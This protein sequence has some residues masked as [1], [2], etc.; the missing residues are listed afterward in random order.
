M[1]NRSIHLSLHIHN[2]PEAMAERA[3]HIFADACEEAIAERGIFRVA[4]SGGKTP[5]P[6]F[7]LL[8]R[9]D[10]TQRLPWN[11]IALYWVD[12]RCVGPDDP[13]SNYGMARRELLTHVPAIQY[14]RMRG[15]EDPVKAAAKYE[16]Q[17]RQDFNL[18]EKEL[19]RFDFMLLGLGEDGHTGSIFPDSPI[20]SETDRLVS[21]VYIP[22]LK[23]D[24]ITLTL[25]V[26]NNSRRCVFLV[27]GGEK[28]K[29][30]SKALDILAVPE[31]PAQRVRPRGGELIWIVDNAAALGRTDQ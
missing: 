13:A 23:A 26:I 22:E 11:D 15:D 24:R 29:P 12:E 3:A 9:S 5:I 18:G 1:H 28:H 8:S 17:L 4:L 10:W 14:F 7:K 16:E 31:L 30:L 20:L 19:P 27:S 6:L 21:D 2:D 25:P